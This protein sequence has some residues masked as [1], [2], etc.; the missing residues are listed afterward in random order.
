MAALLVIACLPI[1]GW[2]GLD[3]F[4]KSCCASWCGRKPLKV[5]G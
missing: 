4:L 5:R 1:G 2:S 3:Y